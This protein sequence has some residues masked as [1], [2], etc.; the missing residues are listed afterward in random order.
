MKPTP[1]K[2]TFIGIGAGNA[3]RLGFTICLDNTLQLY[4]PNVKEIHYFISFFP[5]PSGLGR[6]RRVGTGGLGVG[7]LQVIEM[8]PGGARSDCH[9][10][11]QVKLRRNV[12]S[13]EGASTP[14]PSTDWVE[15]ARKASQ[16]SMESPPARAEWMMH[17]ALWPT[18]RGRDCPCGQPPAQIP[19]CAPNA[20]GSCL[21]CERRSVRQGRDA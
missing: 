3:G 5:S 14:W 11:P 21:G 18:D 15:P 8:A 16:S 9:S 20:L 1:K 13:V 19:A 12:P 7:P 6:P 17:M 10:Q 4:L 2:I